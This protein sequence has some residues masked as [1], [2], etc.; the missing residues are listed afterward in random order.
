MAGWPCADGRPCVAGSPLW[1]GQH[2]K[3]ATRNDAIAQSVEMSRGEADFD[4]ARRRVLALLFS[5]PMSPP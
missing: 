2:R 3:Q 4:A 1:S 5:I